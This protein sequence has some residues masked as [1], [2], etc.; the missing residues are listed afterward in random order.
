[1][2]DLTLIN[3]LLGQVNISI[4]PVI[5]LPVTGLCCLVFYNRLGSLN[6][7]I[8]TLQR[9]LRGAMSHETK[10]NPKDKELTDTLYAEYQILL[11]R[12]HAIRRSI[13]L[14][15]AA[16]FV[17][18]ITGITV[19]A[20]L[21]CPEIVFLTLGLW[22]LGALFFAIAIINGF[23]EIHCSQYHSLQIETKLIE[24]WIHPL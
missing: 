19:I 21:A 22:T 3:T 16:L 18:A 6:G 9:E 4:F 15:F 2:T 24:Q 13:K 17:F 12:S 20:S 8:H 14:C 5:L 1:M 10:E 11:K 7:L 23:I